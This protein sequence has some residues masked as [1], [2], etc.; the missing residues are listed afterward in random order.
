MKLFTKK[1][2]KGRGASSKSP[3]LRPVFNGKKLIPLVALLLLSGAAM[4]VGMGME[5]LFAQPVTLVK[6]NGEFVHVD[7]QEVANQ[8]EPFL[9]KGFVQLNLVAI[10]EQLLK[11]P[12]IFD[13]SIERHWPNALEIIVIE[14]VA[15]ASWGEKGFLNY[16]GELF[17]PDKR[18]S[19][20]GLPSLNGPEGAAIEVMNHF[21]ELS[22]LLSPQGLELK[23]LTLDE[24]GSWSLHL[25]S[26]VVITLGKSE[27]MEKMKRFLQSYQMGLEKDFARIESID[28]RYSNGFAV[29]WRK[30][31]SKEA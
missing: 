1:K 6:V 20:A 25:E 13:V 7:R 19:I 17:E 21:R 9:D 12:W 23:E 15:I 24:R 22:E 29:A 10:R 14:Q 3:Q 28:M 11:Q 2:S 31:Q 16:R 4:A 27:I 30:Q 5:R 18:V 26:N 8:V